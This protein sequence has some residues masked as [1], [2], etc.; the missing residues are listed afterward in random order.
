MNSVICD[1]CNSVKMSSFRLWSQQVY[2]AVLLRKRILL[3]AL[4]E[5][6]RNTVIRLRLFQGTTQ[7]I[8]LERDLEIHTIILGAGSQES[9]I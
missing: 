3:S 5:S 2:P 4:A 7:D 6:L 1:I 8:L 9:N